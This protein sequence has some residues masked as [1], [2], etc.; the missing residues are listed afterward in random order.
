MLHLKT[1]SP[2]MRALGRVKN[3]CQTKQPTRQP[4]YEPN[5]RLTKKLCWLHVLAPCVCSYLRAEFQSPL[6]LSRLISSHH[7]VYIFVWLFIQL[8]HSY[9]APWNSSL[10]RQYIHTSQFSNRFISWF[11]SKNK[12]K[13]SS[14]NG[15]FRKIQIKP[16]HQTMKQQ[17]Y[18]NTSINSIRQHEWQQT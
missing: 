11:Y 1:K 3:T 8:F 17:I 4:I 15:H 9:C 16:Q 5:S 14:R 18:R 7:F 2:V 13:D 6:I 10:W 12:L